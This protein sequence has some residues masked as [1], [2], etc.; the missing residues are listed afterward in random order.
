MFGREDYE[1]GALVR[2]GLP[3]L[4]ERARLERLTS[5]T[6]FNTIVTPRAGVRS[7]DFDLDAERAGLGHALGL[8]VEADRQQTG[9]ELMISA[10]VNYLDSNNPGPGFFRFARELGLLRMT[11]TE[12][13]ELV[14]WQGQV[15]D[16]YARYA[17]S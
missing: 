1:W 15:K 3:F 9:T 7:F 4:R 14:F 8:I 16:L 5:Y 11:T 6:E 17:S 10:L 2:E 13:D 12:D